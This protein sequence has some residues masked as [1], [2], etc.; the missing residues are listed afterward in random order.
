MANGVVTEVDIWTEIV[1]P[2]GETMRPEHARAIL[3]WRFTERAERRMRQL[4]ERNNEGELS[5]VERE[6][7]EDYVHVGQVLAVLQARARLSLGQAY[8][9]G[10][11]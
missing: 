5:D 10:N 7:L 2:E 1:A 9:N 8:S 11:A 4:A 6:E 3:Q